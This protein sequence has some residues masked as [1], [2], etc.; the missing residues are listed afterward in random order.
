MQK[1]QGRKNLAWIEERLIVLASTAFVSIRIQLFL[2]HLRAFSSVE[3][4]GFG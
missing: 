4:R 1:C 2:L 3:Y